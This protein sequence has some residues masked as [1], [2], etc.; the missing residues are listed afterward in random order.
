[1]HEPTLSEPAP[2]II[3]ADPRRG[4]G[5]SILSGAGAMFGAAMALA[6]SG[7]A[8]PTARL[9]NRGVRK[10]LRRYHHGQDWRGSK[11]TKG[12]TGAAGAKWKGSAR[13]KRATRRGGNHGAY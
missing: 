6:F 9:P 3:T 4:Y 7:R 8:T 13:A 12:H 1:M 2:I 5:R 11:R 10:R